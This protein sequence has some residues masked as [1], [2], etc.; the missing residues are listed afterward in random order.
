VCRGTEVTIQLN[1]KR[2][3]GSGLFLF[4]G[5]LDR[6]LPLYCSINS[7]SRLVVTLEGRKGEPRKWPPRMGERVLL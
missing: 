1:E 6:F 3:S 5:V 2:F 4:A 7:F